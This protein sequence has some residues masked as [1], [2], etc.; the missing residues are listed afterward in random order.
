M[1][2]FKLTGCTFF[3]VISIVQSH[4]VTKTDNLDVISNCFCV[5]GDGTKCFKTLP[6]EEDTE[7]PTN[8]RYLQCRCSKDGTCP[9][10]FQYTGKVLKYL[11]NDSK[12]VIWETNVSGKFPCEKERSLMPTS[13]MD[14]IY[15]LTGYEELNELIQEYGLDSLVKKFDH[16]IF[17]RAVYGN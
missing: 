10:G 6:K 2:S 3:I 17:K 5:C 1:K 4:T 14:F 15:P 16:H 12:W 7:N 8:H 11:I 9:R 13:V